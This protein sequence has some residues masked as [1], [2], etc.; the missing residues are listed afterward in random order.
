LE[1][2]L[3]DLYTICKGAWQ[4][5]EN[6]SIAGKEPMKRR[7]VLRGSK[8]VASIVR[9]SHAGYWVFIVAMLL[10]P[11]V[12]S[13]DVVTE[14]NEKAVACTLEAKQLPFVATRTMAAVHTAMFDAVNSIEGHLTPYK[15]KATSPKGS[16][17]EAAAVSAAYS[18]LLKLCSEQ[19]ADLDAAYRASLAQIPDGDG[20]SAGVA[21][22]EKVAS[23]ILELRSSDGANA[24]NVYRPATT[25]GVY[26]ATTL[27]I[28]TSWGS[29]VPWVLEL[30][31]QFRP[32]PPTSLNSQEWAHDYNEIKDLGAKKSSLR[33]AEQ[34]DI[35]R[36]WV[37][38]GPSSWDPLVR[39]LASAPGRTLLANARLFAMVEMAGADAYISVFDAKY[40]FNF[41]R[42]VTAIRNGDNDG[43]DATFRVPDWEPL[44]DT[45]LHPEYPCAHC[46]TSA[47]VGTVLESEFGEGAVPVLTMTSPTA[48]G[49]VRKWTSIREW[50]DE[51]S[52]AR[53][54]GGIHYRNSIVVGQQ[55]GRKIGTLIVQ[56]CLRPLP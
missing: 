28:G 27:P 24:P 29:V 40:T 45:P 20:K 23:Q 39:Q 9:L 38:T 26:I 5:S 12:S 56:K 47:A 48:P 2:E 43:N 44:I 21:I 19:K 34:S 18:V 50:K 35:A 30:G 1:N 8:T 22:G 11:F 17:P 46:I 33:T 7:N 14:W 41:W 37:I 42:P 4:A 13:A 15:I 6:V 49:V 54:Y 25:P 16:S 31:S 55:M 3:G 53:I 51:V 36:F 10:T 32:S 52:A